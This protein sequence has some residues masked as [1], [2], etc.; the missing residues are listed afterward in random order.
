MDGWMDGWMVWERREEH[1]IFSAYMY[2][3]HIV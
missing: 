2:G 1:D 3:D